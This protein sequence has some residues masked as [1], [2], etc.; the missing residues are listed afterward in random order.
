[1]YKC[2]LYKRIK[3]FLS[4]TCDTHFPFFSVEQKTFL[5]SNLSFPFGTEPVRWAPF[6]FVIKACSVLMFCTKINYND[7]WRKDN[8][9]NYY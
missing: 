7:F 9:T 3:F 6:F 5:N 2:V 1:M 8:G 4:L